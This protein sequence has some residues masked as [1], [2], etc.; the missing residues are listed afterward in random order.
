MANL[1]TRLKDCH[2]SRIWLNDQA[3]AKEIAALMARSHVYWEDI[4][5]GVPDLN[6]AWQIMRR[7]PPGASLRTKRL[8][9]LRD[10]RSV[11]GFIEGSLDWPRP[12]CFHIGLLMVDVSCRRRGVGTAM[13]NQLL[14][15]L[16]ADKPRSH[17][18][19]IAVY[20]NQSGA[21]SFW[22]GLRFSALGTAATSNNGLGLIVMERRLSC[23]WAAATP[24][25]HGALADPG[26]R[27]HR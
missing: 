3:A 17:D 22:E 23:P 5:H 7:T 16:N 9:A 24:S 15:A 20:A 11:L 6:D 27:T 2:F 14:S 26:Q 13:F 25:A 19:R 10:Q 4:G 1:L 12:G 18:V 8:W 21:L